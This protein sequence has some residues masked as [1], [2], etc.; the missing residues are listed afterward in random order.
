MW[1]ARQNAEAVGLD[2]VAD[3]R[4][5]KLSN[6]G[7]LVVELSVEGLEV[8]RQINPGG[9]D[10]GVDPSGWTGSWSSI[11]TSTSGCSIGASTSIRS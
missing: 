8:V 2:L 10:L 3:D 5:R 4:L 9:A 6:D 11:H 1:L 7:E